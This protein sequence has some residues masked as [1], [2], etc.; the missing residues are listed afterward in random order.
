[1]ECSDIP[2]NMV[3]ARCVGIIAH[4]PRVLLLSVTHMIISEDRREM[5]AVCEVIDAQQGSPI[6]G[7]GGNEVY[8]RGS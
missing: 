6:R 7:S 3:H 8:G 5:R 1:M 2:P 4:I